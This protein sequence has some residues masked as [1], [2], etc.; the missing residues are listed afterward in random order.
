MLGWTRDYDSLTEVLE[1]AVMGFVRDHPGKEAMA[2]DLEFKRIA[3]GSLVV[4]QIREI[5][6]DPA[7]TRPPPFT[8]SESAAFEVF[9][10][11]GKDLFANHRLKSIWRF[12]SLV[13]A[14]DPGVAGFDVLVDLTHHDGTSIRRRSGR[15]GAFP[16]ATI[17]ASGTTV[18]YRWRWPE[19]DQRGVYTVTAT[20]PSAPDP[21][22]PLSWGDA[23]QVDLKAAYDLP[24]PV[25]DLDG[26]RK[27]VTTESTRLVPLSRIIEGS[28]PR[29]RRVQ[30]GA[31]SVSLAYTLSF[32]KVGYPGIGIYDMKSWP[33]V[34][35]RG[36][37]VTGLT[38]E[39]IRLTGAF[40][41]T[42]DS[43]R[44]NFF[45]SFLFEPA[46][47]PGVSA[48]A[49][50]ELRSANIRRIRVSYGDFGSSGIQLEGWDG[51]VRQAR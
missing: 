20:F 27:T 43:I 36:T 8:L 44:H 49:L 51:L 37:T 17:T 14:G 35:W 1:Y 6:S 41:Q 7:G 38:R 13:F 34:E 16:E 28:L 11:H 47:D 33:L 31:V 24:Q 29:Q 12:P 25:F 32:L 46:L 26:V 45:E 2:L 9:Q 48:A 3:P 39:P 30:R 19:G 42:Y 21:K 23:L 4:K 5:P 10:H 15:I 22:R 50:A 18:V 40:S